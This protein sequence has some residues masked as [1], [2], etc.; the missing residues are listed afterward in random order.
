M[1]GDRQIKVCIVV[2]SI[3]ITGGQA[4][5]ALRLV[6]GLSREQGIKAELLPI[7]PR[8]PGQLRLLQRIKY[9]R[10]LVTSLAYIATLLVKL[11]R[12]DVVHVFS[13]SYLS[14][15]L[16]PTPAVLIARLYGKPVLLNYH[17]GEAEDHLE[18]WPKTAIPIIKMADRVFVPSRYLVDVFSRFGIEAEA[19]FNTVDLSQF[20]FRERRLLRPVLLSNRNFESHYNVA[21]VLRAFAII[22]R[23]RPDARLIIAGDGSERRL[24]RSLAVELGLKNVEFLGAVAPS[25]MPDL[26]ERADIFIN[27]STIDNMPLSI[28]EAFASGTVV[29]T[30]DAGGI[31]YLVRHCE[32]GLLV[33]QQDHEALARSVLALLEDAE[34][35][36]RIAC[37]ARAECS[38]YTWDAVRAAWLSVYAEL[39]GRAHVA[40]RESGR[41]G[42]SGA[43]ASSPAT[44]N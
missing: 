16:A 13:A 21:C 33:T 19:I 9:V 30:S 35:A 24:L 12:F 25:D 27:A 8:L 5:Q 42:I 26:Y 17:S 15:L 10:T 6:E 44:E 1:R 2:A 36:R 23:A 7:N 22:E 20:S 29:V 28:I 40:N 18:R 34:I 43:E 31:P 32:T 14:F 3:D 38:K 37:E 39:A 41:A 11:P 4:V